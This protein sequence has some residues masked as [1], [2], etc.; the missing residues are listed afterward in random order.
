MKP[1]DLLCYC[2]HVTKRKVLSYLRVHKPRRPSQLSEC[3]GAGTGCGWC[4]PYL[5]KCFKQYEQANQAEDIDISASEYASARASY[6]E[7]KNSAKDD[8]AAAE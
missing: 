8:A 2:F 7:K 3:G 1:D 6:I 4:V 5:N